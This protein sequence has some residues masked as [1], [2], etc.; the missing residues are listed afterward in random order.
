MVANADQNQAE[1][2][3]RQFED[4]EDIVNQLRCYK[5]LAQD[6]QARLTDKLFRQSIETGLLVKMLDIQDELKI[7]KDVFS[8][9]KKALDKFQLIVAEEQKENF[10]SALRTPKSPKGKPTVHFEPSK[11]S[12]LT[13]GNSNLVDS[14]M[15]AVEE[16]MKYADKL[17]VEVSVL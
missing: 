12:Q 13:E 11:S 1:S 14:N 10:P 2:Q 4:F 17:S 3:A 15:L 9:Q 16:M 7:I 6:K 8:E 5:N